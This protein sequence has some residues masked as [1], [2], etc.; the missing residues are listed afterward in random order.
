MT[1]ERKGDT[2]GDPLWSSPSLIYL[3]RASW[4]LDRGSAR[5]E[6]CLLLSSS[7]EWRS[8]RAHPDYEVSGQNLI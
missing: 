3:G 6:F 7:E 4:W 8:D 2:S 1:S 5:K